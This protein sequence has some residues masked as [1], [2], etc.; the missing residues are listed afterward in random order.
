VRQVGASR[1]RRAR[2]LMIVFGRCP[3]DHG[4]VLMPESLC[5]AVRTFEA[6]PLARLLAG[7]ANRGKRAPSYGRLA[8]ACRAAKRILVEQ[9]ILERTT[10]VLEKDPGCEA[11]YRLGEYG[12]PVQFSPYA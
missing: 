9:K 8:D 12:T 4:R 5:G 7:R 3:F 10:G 1:P 6:A 2:T 11:R